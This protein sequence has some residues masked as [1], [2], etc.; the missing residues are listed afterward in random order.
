MSTRSD[1]KL[2]F[3]VETGKL[4][5]TIRNKTLFKNGF[6]G[7]IDG[8]G[9]LIKIT[10]SSYKRSVAW[11]TL[12][13]G[14]GEA[15]GL[16]VTAESANLP[17][18][19][20]VVYSIGRCI[21]FQPEIFNDK[22]NDL[23]VREVYALALTEEEEGSLREYVGRIFF[24]MPYWKTGGE[25]PEFSNVRLRVVGKNWARCWW[26]L[27]MAKS[28]EG[29]NGLVAGVLETANVEVAVLIKEASG[30]P[31]QGLNLIISGGCYLD[32]LWGSGSWEEY[33]GPALERRPLRIRPERSFR[34]SATLLMWGDDIFSVMDQYAEMLMKYNYINIHPT[35]VAGVFMPY[36]FDKENNAYTLL[37]R[38][39]FFIEWMDYLDHTGLGKYGLKY[40]WQ[41]F[42]SHGSPNLFNPYEM[43]SFPIWVENSRG[44]R[45]EKYFPSGIKA[46][47][48]LVHRRGYKLCLSTRAFLYVKAGEHNEKEK[49]KEI[50]GKIADW[51]IDY[52]ILDF[53]YDFTHNLSWE[54]T[55]MEIFR[56]RYRQVRE[57]V[58][59]NVFIEACGVP[60]GPVIGFADAFRTSRDWRPHLSDRVLSGLKAMYHL[61]GR[62]FWNHP[63]FFDVSETP[64]CPANYPRPKPYSFERTRSWISLLG[65][66]CLNMF[67]GGY[68]QKFATNER[69]ELYK[70]ILPVYPGRARP[71]DLFENDL[72]QIYDLIVK[73]PFGEWHV[74]GL[75]NWSCTQKK[76]IRLDLG[77]IGLADRKVL[78]FDFWNRNFIGVQHGEIAFEIQPNDCKILSIHD[79]SESPTVISTDRHI[80]Q[81]GIELEDLRWEGG[82]LVLDGISVSPEDTSH[83]IFIYVPEGFSPVRFSGVESTNIMGPILK[84][85]IM[86]QKGEERKS[87]RIWFGKT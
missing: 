58:G 16:E 51:D 1:V 15:Q 68:L 60:F 18:L 83:N 55:A 80:T 38:E 48:D 62:C 73:K 46:F 17:K 21:V 56:D 5:C 54:R 12:K 35:P 3:N 19:R 79:F 72:P 70:K 78:V 74:V 24:G 87:W 42:S 65:I 86:F 59:K 37:G 11:K 23:Y 76:T 43:N 57:A 27:H 67:A 61:H 7:F 50:Y 29:G 49:V 36:S 63:E 41:D 71:V 64:F 10:D 13:T 26:T 77:K 8:D 30:K 84:A 31:I 22:D 52:V 9:N 82:R 2:E 32:P 45:V 28:K 69:V 4:T 66:M 6:M 14:V 33:N 25:P 20:W 40:F 47:A 34:M 44:Y 81:G 75:F 39:S 53:H 85:T